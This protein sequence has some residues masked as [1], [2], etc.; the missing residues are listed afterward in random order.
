MKKEET[1]CS[2]TSAYKIQ[3]PENYPEESIQHSAQD[4]SLKSGPVFVKGGPA[5]GIC[6][7]I[8][9]DIFFHFVSDH[10]SSFFKNKSM[11]LFYRGQATF[12]VFTV[13]L[14]KIQVFWDVMMCH[15][16]NDTVL[17]PRRLQSSD[18]NILNYVT[19]YKT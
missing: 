18:K 3:T 16:P 8:V 15:W 6:Y 7:I 12:V 5:H 10:E 4:E 14:L 19:T 17:Y 1:E 13:V 11:C 9:C 2:E